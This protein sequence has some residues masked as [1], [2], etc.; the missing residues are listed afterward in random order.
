MFRVLMSDGSVVDLPNVATGT[1]EEDGSLVC[2]D[3][4]GIVVCRFEPLTVTAFG[5]NDR[6]PL[7]SQLSDTANA[8]RADQAID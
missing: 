6:I 7:T 8:D 3:E 2:R 4:D 1:R 5:L